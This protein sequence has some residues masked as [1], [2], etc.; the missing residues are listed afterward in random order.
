MAAMVTRNFE[1]STCNVEAGHEKVCR[2]SRDGEFEILDRECNG[3]SAFLLRLP[4]YRFCLTCDTL[5]SHNEE[6]K[7]YRLNLLRC[8]PI[9][10]AYRSAMFIISQMK[11]HRSINKDKTYYTS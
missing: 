1:V 3:S 9:A 7:V 11:F 10:F 5:L 2:L 6:L 8:S 4:Y